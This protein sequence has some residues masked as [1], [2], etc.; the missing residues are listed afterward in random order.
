[1]SLH[2]SLFSISKRSWHYRMV[3]A[4]HRIWG[5]EIQVKTVWG[6]WLIEVPT[7]VVVLTVIAGIVLVF[8][9]VAVW[10]LGALAVWAFLNP[11][12]FVVLCVITIV[13]SVAVILLVWGIANLLERIKQNSR[14]LEVKE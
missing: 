1:M 11:R 2:S 9:A 3:V 7:A 12:D 13:G 14:K 4:F 5:E 8:T 10:G 6:Y